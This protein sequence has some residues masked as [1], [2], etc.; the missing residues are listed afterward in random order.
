MYNQDDQSAR[1]EGASIERFDAQYEKETNLAR[2]IEKIDNVAAKLKEKYNNYKELIDFISYLQSAESV[3]MEAK[4]R[5]LSDD[6]AKDALIRSEIY[7]MSIN[8]GV[9]QSVFNSIY[10]DFES[11]CGEI[12]AVYE[13]AEKL[14]EKNA[15]CVECGSFI[16]YLRDVTVIFHKAREDKK[17]ASQTKE[18]IFGTRMKALSADGR[19]E[20]NTLEK[21]YA[22]FKEA[23][24]KV[25]GEGS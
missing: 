11:L 13:I 5:H 21:I 25:G 4:I 10:D 23:L 9:D 22:E 12:S 17:D 16:E 7:L 20:L 19:P 1:E 18:E 3:F 2:E 6:Q 24:V 8:L 15:D 14:K